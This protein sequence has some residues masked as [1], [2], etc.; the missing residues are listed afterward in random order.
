MLM[1][2]EETKA[3]RLVVRCE[4][5]Q[6]PIERGEEGRAVWDARF[7]EPGP[8]YSEVRFVHARCLEA[9]A[10]DAKRD[11]DSMELDGFIR[12]LA[13]NLKVPEEEA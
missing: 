5:C 11:Q 6:A 4:Y 10:A 8:P 1:V 13:F 9:Y 3:R 2:N 12:D 7:E